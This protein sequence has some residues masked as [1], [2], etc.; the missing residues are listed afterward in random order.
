MSYYSN[1]YQNTFRH[2]E[3]F[4]LVLG[5][6]GLGKT[7]GILE[8]IKR[9]TEENKRYFYVANRLQ[10]LNELKSDLEKAKIGYCLQK[11]DDEIIKEVHKQEFDRLLDNSIIQKYAEQIYRKTPSISISIIKNTFKFIKENP[12][13]AKS[14]TGLDI[15][16]EQTYKVFSFFRAIIK[17]A[18]S[19][20]NKKSY[21]ELVNNSTVKVLFPYLDFKSNPSEKRI[22]LISLH[23]AFYGFFDGEQSI[24]LYKLENDKEK[25]EQNII[26]LDEFDFLENDLLAQICKDTSIEQ[27]F[28]FVEAFYNNLSKYK[29]S[30]PDF[31]PNNIDLKEQINEIVEDVKTLSNEYHIDFPNKNHFVCTDKDLLGK[32][33]FQ[34]RYS[35]SNNLIFLNQEKR[36]NSFHLQKADENNKPNS[37]VLLNVVNQATTSI[38]RIFKEL[39]FSEPEVYKALVEHCFGTSDMYKRIMTQI[40]QH[41]NR[42][43]A[44]GTNDSKLY[45]NGFG[46]YEIYNFGYPTDNEEIE[47]KYYSV[48]TTPESILLHLTK[49]NLVFGLS[50]TAEINRYVKNFDLNW[51][52]NELGELYFDI[53]ASDKE[54]IRLANETKLKKRQNQVSVEIAEENIFEELNEVIENVVHSNPELFGT[55]T[56]KEYRKKR[57]CSFFATLQWVKENKTSNN[58][59]L[60]FFSSYKHILYFFEKVSEPE[61]EIYTIQAIDNSLKNCFKLTFQEQDFIVLFLDASQGKE[62]AKIE[63]NKE[64]YYNLFLQNL[65]VLLITTYASAGNGVNLFYYADKQKT[66]KKDFANIHLLDSPFYFFNPIDKEKDTEQEKIEKIKYNI[67]YLAKLEKNKVI[68]E[69]QFRTYLNKI[70][71]IDEFNGIYLK[72]GDGLSSLVSTYIQ[73]LG[74]VERAWEQMDN[75]IIR[76]EREVYNNLEV[77]STNQDDWGIKQNFERN[78]PYFSQNV[79]ALFQQIAENKFGREQTQSH[80]Q[81]EHLKESDDKCKAEIKILL[82]KLNLVRANKLPEDKIFAI[83]HEWNELRQLALQQRFSE[84]E[85]HQLLKKYHCT[86]NTEY[87]DHQRKCLWMQAQTQHIVPY[88]VNPDSSFYPWKL[89]SVFQNIVNSQ[90]LKNYF[91]YNRYEQGFRGKGIY[92]TPYFYQCILAGAIGEEAVKAIFEYEQINL[93]EKEIDNTLFELIDLKIENK[94]WYIDAKNYSEQTITNFQLDENDALYHPKLN[95]ETF[96]QKA[97]EKLAKIS[98]FHN[99]KDCKIIYINVFGTN[100]RPIGYYDEYFN[101]V[102]I[103]FEKA[104]IIVVQSMI[105]KEKAKK[106]NKNYSQGFGDFISQIKKQLNNG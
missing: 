44:V 7:S 26:F 60:L 43:R 70:R 74:R 103:N 81:D 18:S 50:A 96:K 40:R 22:F 15:L 16:R 1:Y 45:Y 92:F 64:V 6:T 48:F 95:E 54:N 32:S 80:H 61:S 17:K 84:Y 12:E 4:K 36:T 79:G 2:Q 19:E 72:T 65:P 66:Q 105:N 76:L 91:D 49:N 38:I 67:Y 27:P 34:T 8:V 102:G 35:I 57:V 93:S 88:E 98:N 69:K 75:Q 14:D 25:G 56:Q 86:F 55:G 13:L 5:G 58:S 11:R 71:N 53:D 30:F 29:L 63:N 68:T 42:R 41:P 33:I 46:L 20:P 85:T 78:K 24:N 90:I 73:A 9:N 100:E 99:Q 51:L 87:Y 3:G 89:D 39:E 47:L 31:L 52:K 62:I 10:L 94:T 77:F 37:F 23:K 82:A 28:N 59:N 101:E 97:Q 104:K 21:N 106:D 83:R